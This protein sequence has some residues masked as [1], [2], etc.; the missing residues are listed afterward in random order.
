LFL[1]KARL[2]TMRGECGAQSFLGLVAS[3]DPNQDQQHEYQG[4][5]EL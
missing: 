4:K 5:E 3:E 1:G 2:A